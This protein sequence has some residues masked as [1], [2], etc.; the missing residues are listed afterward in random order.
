MPI[1]HVVYGEGKTAKATYEDVLEVRPDIVY[2]IKIEVLRNDLGDFSEK[3]SSIAL[4]GEF[5]GD[6]NPDGG[7]YDCTFFDC[8]R[9]LSTKRISSI[10]GSIFASLT[11]HG[12]S[13][14]CDCNKET[15]Q[16]AKEETKPGFSPMTAVA[17]ITLTPLD[18]N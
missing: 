16:C 9:T 13:W 8:A 18:G 5:I 1:T 3:V 6:C 14:D 17:K 10:N 12:Y 2:S 4:N 11:Y 7:D 15:W